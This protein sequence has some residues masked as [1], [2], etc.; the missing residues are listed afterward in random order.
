[1]NTLNAKELTSI[2]R[3]LVFTLQGIEAVLPSVYEQIRVI[4]EDKKSKTASGHELSDAL[5]A[6]REFVD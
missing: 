3:N 5:C 1:M 6:L 2:L 4:F